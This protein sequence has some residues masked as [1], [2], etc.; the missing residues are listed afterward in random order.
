MWDVPITVKVFRIISLHFYTI[1]P[2]NAPCK[3]QL[4][5]L[6]LDYIFLVFVSK[7]AEYLLNMYNM[8]TV[9]SYVKAAICIKNSAFHTSYSTLDRSWLFVIATNWK[10]VLHYIFVYINSINVWKPRKLQNYYGLLN[11]TSILLMIVNHIQYASRL[12][13]LVEAYLLLLHC[14]TTVLI[15][16]IWRFDI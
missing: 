13:Y 2:F 11:K 4:L 7:Q 8:W 12:H 5:V 16:I 15:L 3:I 9:F 1:L 14:S 6:P 10:R